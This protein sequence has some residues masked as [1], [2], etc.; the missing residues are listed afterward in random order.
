[1]AVLAVVLVR[2]GSV[3]R[4]LPRSAATD[5][6]HARSRAAA[7]PA[8]SLASEHRDGSNHVSLDSVPRRWWGETG[9]WAPTAMLAPLANTRSGTVSSAS[10]SNAT[11]LP[12]PDPGRPARPADR[13]GAQAS[14]CPPPV[15]AAVDDRTG[16]R[17]ARWI[18]D[19]HRDRRHRAVLLAEQAARLH[20]EGRA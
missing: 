3:A 13:S 6:H 18:L 2:G 4:T 17:L 19:R 7:N 14:R 11:S 8:S 1:M 12:S 20:P 16:C 10:A 5:P 15:R 9:G